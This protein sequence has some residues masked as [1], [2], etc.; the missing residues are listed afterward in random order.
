[1]DRGSQRPRQP[2]KAKRVAPAKPWERAQAS[3]ASTSTIAPPGAG[4]K[5]WDCPQPQT[6]LDPVNG[7]DSATT[8]VRPQTARPWERTQPG[9]NGHKGLSLEAV[10]PCLQASDPKSAPT[11][12]SNSDALYQLTGI[13]FTIVRWAC[14]TSASFASDTHRS[15]K[16][17][18]HPH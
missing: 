17:L 16:T 6:A 15:L 12:T 10:P 2:K 14:D 9:Q 18:A 5:P 1:M 7:T 3:G 13:V 8:P 4:P 11:G